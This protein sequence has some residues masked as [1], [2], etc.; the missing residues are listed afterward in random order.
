MQ[1]SPWV[2]LYTEMYPC[3]LRI[4][5][6]FGSLHDSE[7]ASDGDK[8]EGDEDRDVHACSQKD[9]VVQSQNLKEI[10]RGCFPMVSRSC[11]LLYLM[12]KRGRSDWRPC[13]DAPNF[14]RR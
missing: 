8:A 2:A 7:G 11:I 9:K 1:D 4:S 14:V 6:V 13:L 5:A 3:S 10:D 12:I